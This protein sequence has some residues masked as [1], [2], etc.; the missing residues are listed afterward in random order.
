VALSAAGGA[1]LSRALIRSLS[2]WVANLLPTEKLEANLWE[3]VT[4][5]S[6]MGTHA[7]PANELRARTGTPV[8]VG[9]LA[10]SLAPQTG[11]R[12][13]HSQAG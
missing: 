5:V 11:Q 1:H 3:L 2:T 13:R 10:A 8:D 6:R 7:L 12:R 4:S 9:P